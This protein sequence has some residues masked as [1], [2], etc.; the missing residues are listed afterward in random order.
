MGGVKGGLLDVRTF[1]I[2]MGV[3]SETIE[4]LQQVGERGFEGFVLWAGERVDPGTFRFLSCLVPR[5][6]AMVTERGLLVTVDGEALFEVNKV[7]HE[8]NQILAAQVHSHPTA[9]YHSETD[10]TY[11]LV[12]LVGALSIVLPDFARRAPEDIESWAWYRLS[13]RAK[14]EPATKTTEVEIE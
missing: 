4:F 11:P 13:G 14:W 5:Q 3:L 8:R 10:D 2:P 9:A 7:V 6:S 12:T 1:V